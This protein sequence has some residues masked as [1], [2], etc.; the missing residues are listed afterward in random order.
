MK[1]KVFATIGAFLCAIGV[2]VASATPASAQAVER[3]RFSESGSF[4]EQEVNPE[5]CGGSVPFPVLHTFSEDAM[6]LVK[7]R[8]GLPYLLLTSKRTDSYTNTLNGK[9]LTVRAV[10]SGQ[11]QSII[12]H[13]D[14]TLTIVFKAS[15]AVKSYGPDGKLLF[16]DTGLFITET[17]I[18]DA[19]TP[20]PDDD[21]FLDVEVLAQHGQAD[22]LDRDFCD[23]IVTLLG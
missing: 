11:D 23:D 8:D 4:I 16:M 18:D 22:T 20:D 2:A 6:F 17:L 10:F 21:I 1:H 12:D 14:G 7:T 3:E 19:G 5:F 9:T 13:G 15:G